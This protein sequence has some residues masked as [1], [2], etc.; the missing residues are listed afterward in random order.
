MSLTR[1]IYVSFS[2]F[3]LGGTTSQVRESRNSIKQIGLKLL[4][5]FLFIRVRL[6][7]GDT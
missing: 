4:I 6:A 7:P 1:P 3:I 5:T 2:F